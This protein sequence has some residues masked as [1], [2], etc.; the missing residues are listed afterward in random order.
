MVDLATSVFIATSGGPYLLNFRGVNVGSS[1]SVIKSSGT[2]MA[3]LLVNGI[4]RATSYGN[5]G[6]RNIAS[7][8]IALNLER[9]DRVHIFVSGAGPFLNN[10]TDDDG[11]YY[12]GVKLGLNK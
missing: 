6:E 4:I 8:S 2:W 3:L 10:G 11:N 12:T 7:I 9:G 1:Y 5:P